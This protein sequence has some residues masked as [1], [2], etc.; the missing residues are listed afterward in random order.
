MRCEPGDKA[1]QHPPLK[2]V[3]KVGERDIMAEDEIEEAVRRFAP[4]VPMREFDPLTVAR[5]DAIE[6]PLAIERLINEALRQ[7]A[8][9]CWRKAP[10]PRAIE[11][12]AIDIGRDNRQARAWNGPCDLLIPDNLHGV[13]FFS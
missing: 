13:W 4:E 10:P 6:R 3:R 7:F 2:S 5:L 1:H 8:Q 12:G 11:H 9:T